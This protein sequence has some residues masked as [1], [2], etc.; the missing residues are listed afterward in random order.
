MSKKGEKEAKEVKEEPS[1]TTV[2]PNSA[3]GQP[4]PASR[5]AAR[6]TLSAAT[7][8][9]TPA[10][11]LFFTTDLANLVEQISYDG[12]DPKFIRKSV[13]TMTRG[14]S[15]T[16]IRWLVM[17]VHWGSKFYS[18]EKTSKDTSEA[19]K[20]IAALKT[21]GIVENKKDGKITLARL[22]AAHAPLLLCVRKMMKD[23][24][25]CPGSNIIVKGLPLE[26]HDLAFAC[27]SEASGTLGPLL[28]EFLQKF[29]VV[30]HKFAV[31]EK[32]TVRMTNEEIWEEMDKF[33][34]AA[35][36]SLELDKS[37]NVDLRNITI[38]TMLTVYGYAPI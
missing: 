16:L 23:K 13:F 26:Y 12:M 24:E 31:S 8:P 5:P 38:N 36:S 29:A 17:Y 32:R 18:K 33:R 1:Q 22:A 35:V 19:Q 4:A 20:A 30:L 6:T 37:N 27:Y 15:K 11:D 3:A 14:D 2:P 7:I 21:S 25:I 28:L 9:D 10:L 34:N